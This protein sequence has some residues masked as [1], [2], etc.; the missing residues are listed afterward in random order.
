[1]STVSPRTTASLNAAQVQKL[2]ALQLATL[3]LSHCIVMWQSATAAMLT[4]A[5]Q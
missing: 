4:H 3:M 1:M 5:G 2:H